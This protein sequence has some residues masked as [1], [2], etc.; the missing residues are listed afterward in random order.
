MPAAFITYVH[1]RLHG[2]SAYYLHCQPTGTGATILPVIPGL[3]GSAACFIIHPA[4]LSVDAATSFL[5]QFARNF[6][7]FPS[8]AILAYRNQT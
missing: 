5:Y 3:T 1:R 7:F 8:F 4:G 6:S 2:C